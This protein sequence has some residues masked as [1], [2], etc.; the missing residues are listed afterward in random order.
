MSIAYLIC[1]CLSSLAA[2][3]NLIKVAKNG[4]HR[5]ETGRHVN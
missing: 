5:E 3:F 4:I 2:A 1:I